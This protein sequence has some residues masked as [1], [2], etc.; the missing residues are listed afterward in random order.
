MRSKFCSHFEIF[1]PVL[2]QPQGNRKSRSRIYTL[3][4]TSNFLLKRSYNLK[5]RS[6]NLGTSI[7]GFLVVDLLLTIT[8]K[9]FLTI[10]IKCIFHRDLWN[11]I[12]S[13]FRDYHSFKNS[14][15]N[16]FLPSW[17]YSIVMD[18]TNKNKKNKN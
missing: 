1:L 7:F 13:P 5:K 14:D 9:L 3:K 17:P 15:K 10:T 8:L 16:L 2:N 12:Y 18:T 4:F 11:F 6:L